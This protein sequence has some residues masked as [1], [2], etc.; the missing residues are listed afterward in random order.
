[1]TDFNSMGNNVASFAGGNNLVE[2]V[3]LGQTSSQ[4]SAANA[5]VLQPDGKI[6]LVGDA[7]DAGGEPALMIARLLT[8]GVMDPTFNGGQPVIDEIGQGA[9]PSSSATAVTIQ[10][11]GRIVVAGNATDAAGHQGLFLMRLSAGGALDSTFNGGEAVVIQPSTDSRPGALAT[12][13]T[14]VA[15]Q[16]DGKLIVGGTTQDANG[17]DALLV[18]RFNAD[19]SVDPSW[20]GGQPLVS[21]PSSS[22]GTPSLSVTGLAVQ[23][24]GKILIAGYA[25]G[26]QGNNE[27]LVGR[28][29]G[30]LPPIASFSTSAGPVHPDSSVSFSAQQPTTTYDSV[31][32]YDW[33]FGDG[34]TA[35]GLNV[36]HT[37]ATP[38]TYTVTLTVTDAD[39]L[40]STG[41]SSL[42]VTLKSPTPTVSPATVGDHLALTIACGNGSAGTVC[43]GPITVTSH[44]TTEAG[45]TIAVAARAHRRK[46]T[47]VTV[48]GGSYSIATGHKATINLTL[49]AAGRKLLTELYK[50][51]STLRI[52]GTTALT[53]TVTFSY[54]RI[55]SPISFTWDFNARYSV[56]QELTISG[57][58]SKSAVEVICHRGGCPFRR[59]SF[60][61]HTRQL[62]LASDLEHSHLAPGATLELEITA[63]NDVGKVAIFTIRSGARPSLGERCLPPGA[64]RPTACA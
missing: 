32:S 46:T 24:G 53:R 55:R 33:N 43:A 51:P 58:P 9:T 5:L 63:T 44:V 38:G 47:N 64:R 37:Y 27:F 50:L 34:T 18:A 45:R 62:A 39:G 41:Q 52:G 40:A 19:G 56:A 4:S 23:P 16:P 48:A 10:P 6:V 31:V 61:P 25:R 29:I 1:M 3:G 35:T 36:S 2:Q 14:S 49:N 15:V 42:T 30:D 11:D 54:R 20:N 12:N 13:A 28:L 59:R 60:H 57:L 21:Q 7:T 26:A 8:S 22:T 17:H